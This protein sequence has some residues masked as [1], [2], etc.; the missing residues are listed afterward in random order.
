M[1]RFTV[2]KSVTLESGFVG[3]TKQQVATRSKNL[4]RQK[5]GTYKILA[6]VQF[7]AGEDITI[8]KPDKAV[9]DL[10]QGIEEKEK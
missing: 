5:N 2:E 10:L 4:E 8:A 1:P 3:L 6:P 7:K 9:V